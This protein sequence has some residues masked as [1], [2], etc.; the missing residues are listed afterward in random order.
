MAHLAREMNLS[1]PSLAR[2][3]C[4]KFRRPTTPICGRAP[5]P[6]APKTA[7][8]SPDVNDLARATSTLS[9]CARLLRADRALVEGGADVLLVEKP[10]STP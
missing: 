4:D 3:A 6:H 1:L 7:S 8:I 10:S 9:N 2:A 5:G